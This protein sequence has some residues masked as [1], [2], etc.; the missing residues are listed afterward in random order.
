M[1][2]KPAPKKV[3]RTMQ[4]REFDMD[5][6]RERNEL[7]LAAGNAKVNARGDILGPG[8]KII[9][10]REDVASEYYTGRGQQT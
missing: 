3:Y 7:T 9:K 2:M 4:G 6:M 8:G 10:K 1:A 5:K